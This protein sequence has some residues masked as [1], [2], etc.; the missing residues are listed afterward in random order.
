ME[1]H[2]P[3]EKIQ[4]RPCDFIVKYRFFTVEEGGR[5]SGPANQGYKSDFMYAG[6]NPET[7]MIYMIHPEFLDQDNNVVLDTSIRQWSGKAKMWIF[8][9]KF[10]QLHKTRIKVGTKG[11]F[12]EGGH[13]TAECEVIE[14]VGLA[15]H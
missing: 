15:N 9:P 7:D 5:K 13:K 11:F 12:M 6:D 1:L 10:F 2:K 4:N 8:N 3:Y 14:I